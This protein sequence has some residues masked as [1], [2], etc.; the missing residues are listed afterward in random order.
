MLPR[1]GG[2]GDGIELALRQSFGR[3]VSSVNWRDPVAL[4]GRQTTCVTLM[5]YNLI[6]V[7]KNRSVSRLFL[8][9]YIASEWALLFVTDATLPRML[10]RLA[11]SGR[12]LLPTIFIGQSRNRVRWQRCLAERE[13]L[14]IRPV[15]LISENADK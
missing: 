1:R 11:F 8:V 7:T 12:N 3:A 2:G 15:G 10:A 9:V 14:G 5:V 6:V 4:A 13:N